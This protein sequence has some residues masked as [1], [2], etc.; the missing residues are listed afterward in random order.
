[1]M[2]IKQVQE[3]VNLAINLRRLI[4]SF[5]RR[6]GLGSGL[7]VEVLFHVEGHTPNWQMVRGPS[8]IGEDWGGCCHRM[9]EYPLTALSG[10]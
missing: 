5:V 4:R 2:L 7:D 1:M 10:M 9:L 3:S 8:A 6:N